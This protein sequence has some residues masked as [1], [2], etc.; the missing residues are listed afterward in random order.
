MNELQYLYFLD[1]ESCGISNLVIRETNLLEFFR[2]PHFLI[3]RTLSS[4]FCTTL[5]TALSSTFCTAF[6]STFCTTF[7]STLSTALS[8]TMFS[9]T[10]EI[11][12]LRTDN[13]PKLFIPLQLSRG[14]GRFLKNIA[15]FPYLRIIKEFLRYL[16]CVSHFSQ[17]AK[18]QHLHLPLR[19]IVGFELGQ[20]D[21]DKM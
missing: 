9:G 3:S 7:C 15:G 17:I 8:E 13:I 11:S 5:C 10:I 1:C 19:E 21:K 16:T 2:H 14:I 6:C 18:P 12:L 4:T 20:F